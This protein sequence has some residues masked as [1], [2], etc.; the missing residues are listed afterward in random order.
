M[1]INSVSNQSFGISVTLHTLEKYSK[2]YGP[3]MA[4]KIDKKFSEINERLMLSDIKQLSLSIPGAYEKY[5]TKA[6]F[7]KSALNMTKDDF[8]HVYDI[9][10]KESLNKAAIDG[11]LEKFSGILK[12]FYPNQAQKID[13]I[14][15]L[16]ELVET[17]SLSQI[18]RSE[19]PTLYKMGLR[20]NDFK[21]IVKY[22][23]YKLKSAIIEQE[24]NLCQ[25]VN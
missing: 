17:D 3:R 24:D 4:R 7:A 12:S 9:L 16:P 19:H 1:Q 8:D 10:F 13:N 20:A 2:Y 5:R 11:K 6:N 23:T 25:K 22:V 18:F 15:V 21:S 14:K